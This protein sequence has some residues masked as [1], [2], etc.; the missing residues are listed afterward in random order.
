MK[1]FEEA[2]LRLKQ[3]LRVVEDRHAAEALGLTADAWVKRKKR[4]A[5]PIK[6]VFALASQRPELSLDPD[7]IVTGSSNKMETENSREASLLL[8][9]QKLNN[10]DQLRLLNMAQLWSGEMVL[11]LPPK[12]VRDQEEIKLDLTESYRKSKG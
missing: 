4:D 8:C 10:K 6:E 11:A 12:P 5:F 1:N 3:Q 7:W 2:A 9:F